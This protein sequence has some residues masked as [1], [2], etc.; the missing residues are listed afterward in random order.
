MT[1]QKN[2]CKIIENYQEEGTKLKGKK[3][4]LRKRVVKHIGLF[5]CLVL[6]LSNLQ[7]MQAAAAVAVP[8][9][10][11]LTPYQTANYGIYDNDELK[12]FLMMGI[13]Y[14]QGVLGDRTTYERVALYNL[15]GDFTS[16]SFMVGHLDNADTSGAMLNVYTDN[17]LVR[18][19]E[20]TGD[21]TTQT[22]TIDTTNV[23]Q[24]KFSGISGWGR[25]GIANVIGQGGHVYE[26]EVTKI[27]TVKQSGIRTYTCKYCE[28]EY[29]E[30]IDAR[31][32]CN[33]LLQPYQKS[34]VGIYV[35]DEK[36]YFNVMGKRYYDGITGN[37]TTYSKEVFFNLAQNYSAVSFTVGHLDGADWSGA[38]LF[39]Y[40]DGMQQKE[41]ALSGDMINETVT[42]NT[43][44]VTQLRIVL[45]SGWGR[46]AIFDMNYV[47]S[48]RLTHSF[49]EKVDEA[50]G[51]ITYTCKNCGAYY[52]EAY[53]PVIDVT[54][55]EL[56]PTDLELT[57]GQTSRL[58]AIV[59]PSNATDPSVK[60]TSQ[61]TG[62]ATVN[63][64]G[65]VTAVG[66]GRTRIVAQAGNFTAQC[67]VTVEALPEPTETETPDP[68]ETETPDPIE[69]E[70]PNPTVTVTPPITQKPAS[71][72]LSKK[73]V[74]LY[75]GKASNTAKVTAS[76]TGD[77]KYVAWRSSNIA[78]A[79]VSSDG[80]ITAVSKGTAIL[81]A[82]AN[83]ISKTVKV[84]VKNP[85]ITAKKSGKNVSSVT[86]KK[87]R[88]MK[89]S[90]D[91]KPAKSG[92]ILLP[93]NA[94]QQ[95]IA[96]VRISGSK[97]VIV[98]K[99]IGSFNVKLKSGAATKT[100]KITVK[101]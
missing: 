65:V 86:V 7:I 36:S 100:I 101:K 54:G 83:N 40:S 62:V 32:E 67:E 38:T 74:T 21:M 58:N 75:T 60:W 25:Y 64:S 14:Y 45:G 51:F 41:I 52:M 2:D 42:V 76:V 43:Q 23:Q 95:K 89:L 6:A 11:Y 55:I 61:D 20:L 48:L 97:L 4:I 17:N 18:T 46:Y 27:A 88:T 10:H 85:S 59:S 93:L 94:K 5:L 26:S 1:K 68:V 31:V 8:G 69:T 35:N 37:R 87:K 3:G 57:V 98:G 91:V 66:A 22:V 33:P 78:V 24:L 73:S 77:S 71:L 90:L 29:T 13:P 53:N 84:T 28:H 50:G 96:S 72:S 12:S 99:K 92:I 56:N 63:A 15:D 70:E 34:N 49:E 19:I 9:Q 30:M 39:V 16:V 79:S 80:S 81:T 44:G 82:T 47:T